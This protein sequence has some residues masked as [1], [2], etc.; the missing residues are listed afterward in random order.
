MR[1][2]LVGIWLAIAALYAMGSLFGPS[3]EKAEQSTLHS[4]VVNNPPPSWPKT[5]DEKAEKGTTDGKAVTSPSPP[6]SK[7][8]VE[9]ESSSSQPNEPQ[10][11]ARSGS[12][13]LTASEVTEEAAL[14]IQTSE[15]AEEGSPQLETARP[16]RKS[17]EEAGSDT[18][19]SEHVREASP[20]IET[21]LPLSRKSASGKKKKTSVTFGEARKPA[22]IR[23]LEARSGKQKVAGSAKEKKAR[24]RE[25]RPYARYGPARR[26]RGPYVYYE[27]YSRPYV[28]YRPHARPYLYRPYAIA[29][30]GV[31]RYGN[32]YG[33]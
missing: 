27:P 26:Y 8:Q 9:S 21:T 31:R 11:T 14:D 16:L 13:P 7:P 10:P 2:A 24:K 22:N 5:L 15:L 28:Y 18:E 20:E 25:A 12:R 19:T 33:Y 1:R 3:D 17:A 32:D 30:Y 29:P 23:R 6:L 4:E